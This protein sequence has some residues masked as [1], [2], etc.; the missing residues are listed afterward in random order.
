MID[1]LRNCPN[2]AGYLDDNG[3]C[4]FCGSKVYDFVNANFDSP[5]K[6][7]IRIKSGD[8]IITLPILIRTAEVNMR[9]EPVI[10]SVD[11]IV[12]IYPYHC[13]RSGSFDF[14]VIGD[15]LYEE[16]RE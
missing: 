14:D 16:Y 5:T 11:G 2:C 1:T 6:T 15:I 12:P 9:T 13:H 10:T 8:K 7:Y 3:R 4:N